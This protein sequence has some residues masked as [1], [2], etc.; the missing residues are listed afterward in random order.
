MNNEGLITVAIPTFN[1]AETVRSCLNSVLGQNYSNIEI[2]LF[3]D[4]SNDETNTVIASFLPNSKIRY[5]SDTKNRGVAFRRNQIT[6]LARGE[7]IAV[8][9]ADDYMLPERIVKQKAILDSN[10]SIQVVGSFAYSVNRD[11]NSIFL[12]TTNIKSQK[13][14]LL[15]KNTVIHSSIM[16]RKQWFLD[17][18]YDSEMKRCQD[19]EL[20]YRSLDTDIF[21][22]IKN[23]LIIY[24]E[25]IDKVKIE[26]SYQYMFKV[27]SK[28]KKQLSKFQQ[29]LLIIVINFK[30]VFL[31]AIPWSVYMRIAYSLRKRISKNENR[32]IINF[33]KSL[34]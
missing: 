3:D 4:N 25:Q 15:L 8:L 28:H 31:R 30:L 27:I 24:T 29:F 11:T 9:D 26:S 21:Y 34:S 7:Y 1:N 5:F 23:P 6:Q 13:I 14:Y 18:K 10:E 16:G 2:I 32:K 20:W 22:V 33:L 19:M 12:K 17:N